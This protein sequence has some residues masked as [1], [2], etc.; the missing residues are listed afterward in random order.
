MIELDHE[1][2]TVRFDWHRYARDQANVWADRVL[3]AAYAHGFKYVEF[4]HGAADV[5]ARGT[6]GFEAAPLEGRGQVKQLLRR[7]LY[8]GQWRRWAKDR[9]EGQHHITEGRMLIALRE[10]PKPDARAPW[11]IVPPPAY[12]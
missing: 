2:G 3:E 7:R 4:V 12:P 1:S 5:G 9:S 11:P 10:N 8:S 6:P